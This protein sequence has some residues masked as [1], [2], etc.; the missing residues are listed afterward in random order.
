[1][2]MIRFTPGDTKLTRRV[3]KK[4]KEQRLPWDGITENQ[5]VFR[6]KFA[7][8]LICYEVPKEV[9]NQVVEEIDLE[10]KYDLRKQLGKRIKAFYSNEALSFRVDHAAAYEV[11]K[12]FQIPKK[13]IKG[14]FLVPACLGRLVLALCNSKSLSDQLELVK[15]HFGK[16][17]REGVES[18]PKNRFSGTSEE[19]ALKN[20]DQSQVPIVRSIGDAPSTLLARKEIDE[21][22]E[23]C[24]EPRV[25]LLR[26]E[27]EAREQLYKAS[28]SHKRKGSARS[29]MLLP[30]E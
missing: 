21:L 12:K 1:M 3:L 9:Y 18:D 16:S 24:D 20:L 13:R 25:V 6:N 26:D 30:R 22:N 4:C 29:E 27:G 5:E 10:D 7:D 8:V 2:E 23:I 19:L 28:L 14:G 17:A 15:H 11:L